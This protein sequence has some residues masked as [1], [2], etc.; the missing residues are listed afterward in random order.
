VCVSR[1]ARARVFEEK[2]RI[3]L[4]PSRTAEC[5][6]LLFLTAER[7]RI[8]IRALFFTFSRT[9][10]HQQKAKIRAQIGE[11]E[12]EEEKGREKGRERKERR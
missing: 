4:F 12:R 2:E 8:L 3:S 11:G 9:R 7:E 1:C 6:L 10:A 5:E